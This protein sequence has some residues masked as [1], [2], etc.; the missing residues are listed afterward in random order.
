M[1]APPRRRWPP[2]PAST[3]PALRARGVSSERVARELAQAI[4]E[5]LRKVPVVTIDGRLGDMRLSLRHRLNWPEA[6][7]RPCEHKSREVFDEEPA[8]N[9]A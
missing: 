7:L 4:S 6:A 9:A 3:P 1:C 5:E 2:S 8:P